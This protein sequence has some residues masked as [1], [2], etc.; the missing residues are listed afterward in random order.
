MTKSTRRRF[1]GSALALP[2]APFA[3]SAPSAPASDRP[4][5]ARPGTL[6]PGRRW[7]GAAG[8]GGTAPLQSNT[9]S[10]SLVPDER[11]TGGFSAIPGQ[12][13]HGE[14]IRIT[15][16]GLPPQA[17]GSDQIN[18]FRE[19]VFFLEGN[20]VTVTEWSVNRTPVRMHD[21]TM[22]PQGS[23]GFSVEIGPGEGAV[24][25]GDAILYCYLRGEHGLERRIEIPLVINVDRSLDARRR[26]GY[27]DPVRG[28]DAAAGTERAPWRSIYHALSAD[29]VGDGGKVILLSA[30]RYVEDANMVPH[31]RPTNN[32]RMIEVVAAEGLKPE[33]VVITRSSRLSPETRWIVMA[34]LV[35]FQ[36]LT[37][38]L[39]KVP[40]LQSRVPSYVI[41]FS[42][43]RLVDPEGENGPRDARNLDVAYNASVGPVL[44]RDAVNNPFPY[45]VGAIYLS[46]CLL[47]NYATQGAK[48]YRN[49]TARESTDSLAGGPGYDDV[50]VDG[51]F[52]SMK[53]SF[54]LRLHST[55]DLI[56][57]GV[58][59]GP[60]GQTIVRVPPGDLLKT[61]RRTDCKATIVSGLSA[62]KD[63]IQVVSADPTTGVV[64]LEGDLRRQLSP[65]DR[66]RIFMIWHADFCQQQGVVRPDQT[67]IRNL[68]IFR[69]HATSPTAQLFLIQAA[70]KLEPGTTIST[71]GARFTLSGGARP[72]VVVPDDVL[73]LA[74]GPE[75]GE[76]RLVRDFDMASGSGTL[77]DPFTAN[78]NGASVGRGKTLHGLAMALSIL[79]KTGTEAEM[80]QFQDG[81]RNFVLAHNTFVSQPMCLSFRNKNPGHG[82]RNHAQLFN[83]YSRLDADT[84]ELP[85]E[86]LRIQRNHFL[87]GKARGAGGK[88]DAVI[89]RWDGLAYAPGSGL[90]AIGM[91]PLIPFDAFGNPVDHTSPVGAITGSRRN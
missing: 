5:Q 38:D 8:S 43:C 18:Y 83:L 84:P 42:G 32:K 7:N 71:N 37:L 56:V 31:T 11:F 9:P 89:L 76:Y 55:P 4:V 69:Y 24:S 87:T 39:G 58:E 62:G 57:Q 63:W 88:A 77:L 30:G 81:H 44:L 41:G 64:V 17:A 51:Y 36:G 23:V 6:R 78:Q 72:N 90:Q 3:C 27:V 35:Y 46:E 65:S 47:V 12:W 15:A 50:V 54:R 21:G 74:S 34:R 1:I 19:A 91:R 28:H 29:G 75:A 20:T 14:G 45:S 10:G 82:H 67:G 59:A 26:A 40:T 13:V 86:G 16:L 60:P 73:R 33:D 66:V 52:V 22:A 48:L 68:T 80:G 70:V 49:V 25:A 61:G 85:R 53:R 2:F 79:H